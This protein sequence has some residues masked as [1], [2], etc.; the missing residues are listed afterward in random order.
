[1]KKKATDFAD[2]LVP[3]LTQ[4]KDATTVSVIQQLLEIAMSTDPPVPPPDDDEEKPK[5]GRSIS[6]NPFQTTNP[7][8]PPP[9]DDEEK[10]KGDRSISNDPIANMEDNVNW[11][12]LKEVDESLV[13][14]V[15]ELIVFC[16]Q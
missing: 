3:H 2:A 5:A 9:D 7:P 4:I 11:E 6:S 13:P 15:K 10:P 1:M 14:V 16:K 12:A 8:V